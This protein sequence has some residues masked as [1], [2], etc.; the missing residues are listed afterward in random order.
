MKIEAFDAAVEKF[1]AVV[2]AGQPP[3]NM[4]DQIRLCEALLENEDFGAA[5]EGTESEYGQ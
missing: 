2:A 4:K 5:L 1:R 3:D